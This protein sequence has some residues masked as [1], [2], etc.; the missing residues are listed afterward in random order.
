MTLH[1]LIGVSQF[2]TVDF[3][4]YPLWLSAQ[5]QGVWV[6]TR[7]GIGP[8]CHLQFYQ[9]TWPI[10]KKEGILN[11]STIVIDW[12]TIWHS[13]EPMTGMDMPF[14]SLAGGASV[15]SVPS[16]T[17]AF[18]GVM[19]Q[20][21]EASKNMTFT[22]EDSKIKNKQTNKTCHCHTEIVQNL[23]CDGWGLV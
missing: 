20:R 8:K 1:V 14:S 11:M 18:G 17:G 5:S 22:N 23:T 6:K 13:L 16:N 19:L 15:V 21:G 12:Q 9:L 10:K 7:N 3:S 2:I 4:H